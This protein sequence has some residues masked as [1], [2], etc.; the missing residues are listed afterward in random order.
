MTAKILD[1]IRQPHRPISA[2]KFA[3]LMSL[4]N[5]ILYNVHV[6][7]YAATTLDYLTL[8]G[9]L[10]LATVIVVIFIV[11]AVVIL[12]LCVISR[13]LAKFFCM[14]AAL[15]SSVA[16]YFVLTYKA[17]LDKTMMSNVFNTNMM[18]ASSYLHYKLVIYLIVLGVIP[19]LAIYKLRIVNYKRTVLLL[20][21]FILV[22]LLFGWTYLNASRL[23]WVDKYSSRLG[24]RIMPWSYIGNSLAFHQRNLATSTE[25]ELL[26][27][28][29]L[30]NAPEK[31][32]VILVIGEAARAINF[33]LYG[34][35][36]AT[37]PLLLKNGA[38]ALQNAVSC[39][40]YTTLSLRCI[41][42]HTEVDS[43]F[44]KQYEPLPSYLHRHGVDVI[45]RTNNWGEPPMKV[46]TYQRN[47]GLEKTCQGERCKF[48]EVLL[49][50]LAERI[51]TSTHNKILV[52]IHHWGNHGP[53]YHTRYPKPFE[54]FQPVCKSVE[55]NQCT[56]DELVNAYD[57]VVLYTDYFLAKAIGLLQD[58]NTSTVLIYVSDHGESLGEYG[59]YLHGTPYAVAPDVQIEIPLIVWMSPEFRESQGIR[60]ESVPQNPSHSHQNIFHSVLGA[61]NMQSEIYNERLD[62]FKVM[63]G[64][65]QAN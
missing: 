62:I 45:W 54:V 1:F 50:G 33:S 21:S 23:L 29:T 2:T 47:N 48:D 38:I 35:K 7:L 51:K 6:L 14:L 61:V 36:R 63:S 9:L 13:H 28:G 5:F 43:P 4:A 11:T 19:S 3:L 37:N 17:V 46:N 41:L 18:E 20:Q 65:V 64:G 56:D 60:A 25:Q 53:S 24:A 16:L 32:V 39:S 59:L 34:Y 10:A 22:V 30:T 31:T 49:H 52:V 40:T 26:P 42:S 58:L 15:I 8:N 44:S 57:N 55:L 27:A 12:L